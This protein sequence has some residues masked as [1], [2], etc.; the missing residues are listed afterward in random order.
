MFVDFAKKHLRRIELPDAFRQVQ[1]RRRCSESKEPS[2]FALSGPLAWTADDQGL[3]ESI[4]YS[5]M[6]AFP[7]STCRVVH[8]FPR[9]CVGP[10]LVPPWKLTMPGNFAGHRSFRR[11][12]FLY[13][14][15]RWLEGRSKFGQKQRDRG[16]CRQ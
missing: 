14:R 12:S 10:R 6:K 13:G 8:R 2:A 5:S 9:D 7:A 3:A 11:L 16:R 4:R 1:S 15:F